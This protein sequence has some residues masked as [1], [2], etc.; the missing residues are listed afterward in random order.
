MND[1]KEIKALNDEELEDVNAGRMSSGA[2]AGTVTGAIAGA[3]LLATAIGVPVAKHIK[4][5]KAAKNTINNSY[6]SKQSNPETDALV[7]DYFFSGDYNKVPTLD[8]FNGNEKVYF[9][10]LHFLVCLHE[11]GGDLDFKESL[12]KEHPE[13]NDKI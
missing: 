10:Y 8:D 5:K 7:Q 1:N 11:D 9:N 3:A 13:L 2:I 6:S 4:K 12:L